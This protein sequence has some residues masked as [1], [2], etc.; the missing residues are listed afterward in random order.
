MTFAD[1][2]ISRAIAWH[3][4]GTCVETRKNRGP[5]IDEIHKAYDGRV[6]NDAY[7]AKFV[8]VVYNESCEIAG[9]PNRLPKS[10]RAVDIMELS[11]KVFVVNTVP[12]PGC[13]FYHK[14][15]KPAVSSGHVG[16]VTAVGNTGI[17]SI[18]GN[19]GEATNKV[20]WYAHSWE[21]IR[22]PQKGYLFS[23]FQ[24]IDVPSF[25]SS[26]GAAVTAGRG[27][28]LLLP[29]LLLGLGYGAYRYVTR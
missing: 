16:I 29:L 3:K 24:N 4:N 1:L 25:S 19:A 11:R 22:N 14:P 13:F 7:C 5:C 20:N 26:S 8:Y 21:R 17:Y 12:A 10:A 28:S 15:S 27:E 9:I 2:I 18:D 23:H 6:N